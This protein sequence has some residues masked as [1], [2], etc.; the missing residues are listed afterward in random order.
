MKGLRYGRLVVIERHSQAS[1]AA[2]WLCRCDCGKTVVVKGTN[3]RCGKT[4]SCGCLHDELSSQRIT[5]Q[6]STHGESK[7]RL[8]GIWVDMKK[9][10]QNQSHWAYHRY[11]GRGITVDPLWHEY[12]PFAAWAKTNGY[13]I[14]LT[15]DRKDNDGPYSPQNCRWV[16]RKVQG[17]NKSS[18]VLYEHQGERLTLSEWAERYNMKYTTL[19]GR[20]HHY[21]WS[22][23]KALS[24]PPRGKRK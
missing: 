9:R 12:E 19:Y 17:R 2:Y 3:L 15:L 23:E 21:G 11:G 6:N 18:N 5:L 13:E 1:R 20:L 24:T 8:Y 4:K 7:T 10:C 16:T 14:T 22:V